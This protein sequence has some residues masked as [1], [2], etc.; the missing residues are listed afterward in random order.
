MR[1]WGGLGGT[2]LLCIGLAGCEVDDAFS[3]QSDAQCF[4]DGAG[5]CQ[6]TGYCS[7]PD[8]DCQSGQRYGELSGPFAK[9]CV[10]LGAMASEPTGV[11]STSSG[12]P[13]TSDDGPSPDSGSPP[14]GGF[15]STG[16]PPSGGETSGGF[17]DGSSADTGY[18][19]SGGQPALDPDLVLW[20][21]FE[22]DPGTAVIDSASM[23]EGEC[24]LTG[25]PALGPGQ[26]GSAA[27]FDGVDDVVEIPHGPHFQTPNGFTLSLWI[28]LDDVP[29]T[30]HGLLTKPLGAGNKNS[31]ELF[32]YSG[33]NDPAPLNFNMHVGGRPHPINFAPPHPTMEWIH[34]AATWDGNTS[35]LWVNGDE[36]GSTPVSGL[37]VDDHAVLVGADLEQEEFEAFFPGRIDDVRIYQRAFDADEIAALYAGP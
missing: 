2:L 21:E 19:S 3:C 34:V 31:W 27:V 30:H 26:F 33:G 5:L 9:S 4:T 29:T 15:E 23:T 7:F 24:Y 14:G 18:E 20:L 13:E 8:E 6:P 16:G 37:D 17:D 12:T 10:P 22:N 1:D 35:T 11:A 36:A 32:F 25:C 28:W